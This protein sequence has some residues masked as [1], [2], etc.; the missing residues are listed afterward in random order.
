M[1][2]DYQGYS[3]PGINDS[4]NQAKQKAQILNY[5]T[6]KRYG[7]MNYNNESIIQYAIGGVN[8][9]DLTNDFGD[10]EV[11]K[12]AFDPHDPRLFATDDYDYTAEL[13]AM[14]GRIPTGNSGITD[15]NIVPTSSL[16]DRQIKK[17]N[18]SLN[19]GLKQ[20]NKDI[21]KGLKNSSLN[22]TGTEKTGE[23]KDYSNLAN[24]G[25]QVGMGLLQNAGNIYDIYRGSKPETETYERYTP[26][27]LTANEILRRNQLGYAKGKEGL[28]AASQG[29]GSAYRQNLKD[30]ALKK[31]YAD[32]QAI[33][34]VNNLNAG[35]TNQAGMYNTE[36]AM[37]ETIANAQN[38]A[39]AR[40]LMGSGISGTGRNI[41]GQIK[42]YRT[43]SMDQKTL[44]AIIASNPQWA[45]SA[46]GKAYIA[47]FK[48]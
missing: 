20:Y 15:P 11:D 25:S 38:R 40:D 12:L 42:D 48:K 33:E 37:R 45:N 34:E 18:K 43:G 21:S 16:S 31:M 35:I 14:A 39:A 22:N 4:Y 17:F 28:A 8:G 2:A 10:I 47:Q 1:H 41:S 32:A 36:L 9:E 3:I 26:T 19:R 7:G 5:G 30:L 44:N 46:E 29:S 6:K 27:T 13:D 24:I 23:T